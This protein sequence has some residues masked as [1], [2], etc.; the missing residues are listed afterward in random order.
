MNALTVSV[1][2]R[3]QRASHLSRPLDRGLETAA[4]F[5]LHLHGVI[6]DDRPNVNPTD[7]VLAAHHVLVP[8][9]NTFQRKA[10]LLQAQWRERRGLPIGSHRGRPLGS[11]IAM[12]FAKETLAGYVTETI[13]S[14]VRDEVLDLRRSAGKLYREP[15]IFE[16]LLSSQPLCFNLFGE[17]KRDLAVASRLFASVLEDPGL[18]VTAIEL[19]H[20]PGRGDARFTADGSAF[21]V[22]VVYRRA[23]GGAGFV[24]IEVKYVEDMKSPP[25]RHRQRY[26]DV[27][28]AM[29]VFLPEA[30]ERVRSSPLEQL[31]RDHLLAGSLSL[32]STSRFERGLF[33]VVYPRGN[34]A[35]AAAVAGYRDCLRDSSTFA[36]WSLEDFLGCARRA[37][38]GEWVGLVEE[39]Y[40]G[41]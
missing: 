14:V 3:L 31:W 10:R 8:T 20:S 32:D 4:L 24:G 28:D 17:L 36:A 34:H 21:D 22:F 1:E 27:A 41:L 18:V 39:R 40:L 5:G 16:D 23:S 19:E 25:A 6:I 35:A 13:R 38:G 29:G 7:D 37:G 26:E 33:S 11:R 9:D 12:P 15:R 30:R 2:Q